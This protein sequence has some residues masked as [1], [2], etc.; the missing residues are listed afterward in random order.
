M[1]FLDIYIATS[2]YNPICDYPEFVK[3]NTYLDSD[4]NMKNFKKLHVQDKKFVISHYQSKLSKEF[5]NKK[6]ND[7]PNFI[8]YLIEDDIPL[9]REVISKIDLFGDYKCNVE[10]NLGKDIVLGSNRFPPTR[11]LKEF[12]NNNEYSELRKK[13]FENT[14]V[15]DLE[16]DIYYFKS[17]LDTISRRSPDDIIESLSFT[18]IKKIK[19]SKRI[20]YANELHAS[21]GNDTG[22]VLNDSW[23][24]F[25]AELKKEDS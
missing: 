2:T 1:H 20:Y 3:S 9:S 5:L 8:D 21:V 15:I 6:E 22:Y 17:F 12:L 24:S 7:C 14:G 18:N 11:V 19:H 4:F 25:L 13:A 10:F 23:I 16:K